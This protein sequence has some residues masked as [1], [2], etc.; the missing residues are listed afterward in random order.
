LPKPE[1]L[2]LTAQQRLDLASTRLR[3]SLL[4]TRQK[5]ALALAAVAPRVSRSTLSAFLDQER[6]HAAQIAG[7]LVPAMERLLAQRTERLSDRT[8]L[9]EAVSYKAVLARGFA[10]V[11]DAEDNLVRSPADVH[12]GSPLTISLANDAAIGATVSGAPA[13]RRKPRV[14]KSVPDGQQSL[15]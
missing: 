9:M 1:N 13:V 6:R 15:F 5:K 14:R 11:T 4:A 12:P 8:K 10:L 2:L 3:S 7:R